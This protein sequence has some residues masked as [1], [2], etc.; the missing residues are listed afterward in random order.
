[1]YDER[2]RSLRTDGL[3]SGYDGLG[4]MHSDMDFTPKPETGE[5]QKSP[6][7]LTN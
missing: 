6:V 5:E 7:G 4:L 2:T 1:M 3:F